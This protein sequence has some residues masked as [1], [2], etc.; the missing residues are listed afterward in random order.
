MYK[1]QL[2]FIEDRQLLDPDAVRRNPAVEW[3]RLGRA[4]LDLGISVFNSNH[5]VQGGSTLATQMEKFRHSPR[6]LTKNPREKLRQMFSAALRAYSGGEHTVSSRRR[7][8]LDYMNSVPLAALPGF[9]EISGLGDGL[10]GYFKAD[11]DRV[12][13]LLRGQGRGQ[14]AELEER[15]QAYRQVLSLFLA[16]RRPSDYLGNDPRPLRRQVD[17]YLPVLHKQRIIDTDLYQAASLSLIH[18]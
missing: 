17:R 1:R 12:N 11:F 14:F 2:L 5:H 13:D 6:G 7:I 4:V 15:A 3:D 9:G 10:W 8:A 16:H 18:I